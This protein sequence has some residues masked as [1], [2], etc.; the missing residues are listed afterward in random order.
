MGSF[1]L[2]WLVLLDV[3]VGQFESKFSSNEGRALISW[4]LDDSQSSRLGNSSNKNFITIIPF[5]LSNTCTLS[6]KLS[7]N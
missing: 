3:G 6:I 5:D 2:G 4:E 1:V 7:T